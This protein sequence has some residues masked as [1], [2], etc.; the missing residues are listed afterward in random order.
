[1]LGQLAQLRQ[2]H[3][4]KAAGIG[5]NGPRPPRQFMQATKPGHPL[6][7]RPQHEVVGVAKDDVGACAAH[8]IH[9]HGL[10]GSAGAYRHES[11]SAHRAAR[12]HNL[13]SPRFAIT[14]EHAK[15][16]IFRHVCCLKRRLESP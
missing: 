13:A 1:M 14:R 11:R 3:D 8:L 15:G 4:L 16:K 12:H 10:D 2:G 5:E 7:A 6:R 9:I